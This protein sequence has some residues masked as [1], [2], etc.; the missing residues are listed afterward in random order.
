M[1]TEKRL[2]DIPTPFSPDQRWHRQGPHHSLRKALPWGEKELPLRCPAHMLMLDASQAILNIISN[3]VNS[4]VPIAAETLK[5]M[6]VYD[7]RKLLG[8]TTLDVV[9]LG[10]CSSKKRAMNPSFSDWMTFPCSHVVRTHPWSSSGPR[11]DVLRRK[12]GPGCV[13]RG[14][15]GYRRS[16]RYHHP[17]P[18]LSGEAFAIPLISLYPLFSFAASLICSAASST[19]TRPPVSRPPQR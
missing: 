5:K 18:V 13:Q 2:S 11:Q 14:R 3:P 15:A 7:K 9:R 8:V 19:S 4:T 12:E 10:L 17:A 16:C 1:R 6:G